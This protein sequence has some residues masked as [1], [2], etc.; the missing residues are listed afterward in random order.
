[1]EASQYFSSKQKQRNYAILIIILETGHA[2]VP[3][4]LTFNFYP[5]PARR[6]HLLSRE[7]DGDELLKKE[8]NEYRKK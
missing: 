4:L 2:V 8:W 5:K 3:T 1:M 7:K 6:H